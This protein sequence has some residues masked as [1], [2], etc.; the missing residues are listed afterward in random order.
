MRKLKKASFADVSAMDLEKIKGGTQSS[1]GDGGNHQ[2]RISVNND[3]SIQVGVGIR[4]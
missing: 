2:I 1:S 3:P 4:F